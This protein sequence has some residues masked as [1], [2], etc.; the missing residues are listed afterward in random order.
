MTDRR[1]VRLIIKR[2]DNPESS[3]RWEEFDIPYRPNMNII[4]CLMEIRKKPLTREGKQTTPIVWD[5][6]CLEHVCGAC[7]MIINDQARQACSTLV[8]KLEQPITIAPMTKFPLVRDLRVD[9]SR[10][11][12][13]LKRAHAWIPIDGTYNLGAGP[14][15]DAETQ[16]IR[17]KLSTCMSCG[18]CMEACPQYNNKTKFVGPAVI[19]QVR[20]MNLHPTGAMHRHERLEAM[21]GE[22]G[23]QDCGNAQNCVRACPKGIPLTESIADI[24]RET[25]FYGLLG[26]LK[27]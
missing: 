12:N 11:F 27:R 17:Y 18:V 16:E 15:L 22:G 6:N 23:V 9:R 10:L 4:I 5:S 14:R 25:T 20:L 7:S 13:D 8:D 26:W 19:N 3:P 21:M 24:N 2:Q 1:T